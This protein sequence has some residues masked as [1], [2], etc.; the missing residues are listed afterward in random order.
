MNAI[1]LEIVLKM[2]KL[3]KKHSKR[4]FVIIPS[5]VKKHSSKN[6]YLTFGCLD[7]N[8]KFNYKNNIEH[9]WDNKKNT[10]SVKK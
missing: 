3:Q 2:T 7:L 1:K 8:Q 4:K 6:K 9:P 5:Q 10:K